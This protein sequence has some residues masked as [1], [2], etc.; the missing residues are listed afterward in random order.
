MPFDLWKLFGGFDPY[1]LVRPLLFRM[2]PEDIHHLTI[3]ALQWG[4]GPCCDEADDPVLRTSVL[5]FE[6]SNPVGLAAGLDKQAEAIDPLMNFGFGFA[7]LGGVTPR[8]QPG[9][10]RP[11]LFRAAKAEAIINRFGFNSVGADVFAER[12]KA[13]RETP[14]RTRHPVGVNLAKNKETTDDAADYSAGLIKVAPYVDFVAVNISSPN[15][16]GLRDL[17]GRERLNALLKQVL[18]TRDAH[19]P[20]LPVLVKIA[21]DLTEEQQADVAAVALSTRIQGLIVGNTTL[22][23]P[24][25]I[26]E[27]IAKEAGGLSGRPLYELSTKVLGN[28]YRLTEGKIPL[29]GCGGISSGQDAYAKIRAGASLLQLYSVLI[30]QGPLAVR[31]IKRDLA[32]L[33]KRDGFAHVAEAV[34][35]DQR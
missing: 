26:P 4:L 7:E 19:A 15:T 29:I 20:A 18:D 25:V 13:W 30:F 14:K 6:F 3:K 21:P 28:I 16:P 10:P 8:P 11:R 27:T 32:V 9:N 22:S 1:P 33:L 12:L 2:D 34:G 23:R 24:D 17:Q 31:R 35:V 5:G